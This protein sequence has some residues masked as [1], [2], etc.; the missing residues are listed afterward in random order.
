METVIGMVARA[1][2]VLAHQVT[3]CYSPPAQESI[4]ATAS[5]NVS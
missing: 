1:L 2:M 5:F 3:G 4:A